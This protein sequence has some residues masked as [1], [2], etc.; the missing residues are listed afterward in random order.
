MRILMLNTMD[1]NTGASIACRR[2]MQGLQKYT[3]HEVQMLVFQKHHDWDSIVG[4]QSSD[5]KQG[6]AFRYFVAERLFFWFYEVSKDER[7]KFSP[8]I[9]G[10]D[11]SRHPLVQ[12]ADVL[13]LHWVNFGFLSLKG[14]GKLLGLQKPIVWTL[15]DMWPFTGGCHHS[16]DCEHFQ[17]TC[18]NCF[19]LKRPTPKDLSYRRHRRKADV[20]AHQ[21]LEVVACSHW[22]AGKAQKSTLF[23][24]NEGINIQ[25]IPNPLDPAI[26]YPREAS[27]T[28]TPFTLLFGSAKITDKRK[29]FEY[30][31]KALQILKEKYPETQSNLEVL[32]FGTGGEAIRPLLP[33]PARDLGLLKTHE[34][35]RHM[36]HQGEVFV[37][38]SLEENLPNMIMESMAC[39]VPVVAYQVGGIPEMIQHRENGY[40]ASYKSAEDLA[41]GIYFV[42]NLYHHEFEAYQKLVRAARAFVIQEFG[43]EII[44]KRYAALYGQ[45]IQ[46]YQAHE[47]S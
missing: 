14:L 12:Q 8:A 10:L 31:V 28:K 6:L 15:H 22:L 46:T 11:L 13:H 37:M 44:S 43:E 35:V 41:E 9:R 25:R 2:I 18:G 4:V 33:Y 30:F 21:K 27:E 26:F 45:A 17:D 20:L 34:D 38:P 1:N 24:K 16:R 32:I 3:P 19:L 5:K 39:E 23:G 29:G 7:F 42:W 36:F 40:L 47:P